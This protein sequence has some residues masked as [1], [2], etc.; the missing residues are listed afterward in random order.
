MPHAL[1]VPR[2]CAGCGRDIAPKQYRGNPRRWCSESCRVRTFR[3]G[4]GVIPTH[5]CVT[6]GEEFRSLRKEAKYCS[7]RCCT[8][9]QSEK[10]R[11]ARGT[12][13][14]T[15]RECV[16]CGKVFTPRANNAERAT[17]CSKE[18]ARRAA[19]R[20]YRARLAEVLFEDV[21]THAVFERDGW[22]CQLCM[23]PI[24]YALV[25]PHPMS[26]SID[27]KVP[28]SLGGAHTFENC[29]AAHMV[30][31][32]S[33]GARWSGHGRSRTGAQASGAPGRE[34]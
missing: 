15:A 27:H 10:R 6:C 32:S 3:N 33:K 31:N 1:T 5:S 16:E 29:Q 12:P 24:D 7:R 25:A 22:T 28:I 23:N 14:P 19:R 30:C 13:P 18:C 34:E 2:T 20:R 11:Q 21:S 17:R 26:P 9:A 8:Q 4:T